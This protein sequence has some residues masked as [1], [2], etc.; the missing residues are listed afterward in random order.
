MAD[1]SLLQI[2]ADDIA[3]SLSS[4]KTALKKVA[5]A[6]EDKDRAKKISDAQKQIADC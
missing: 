5:K 1:S 2:Y 6:A 3:D 4:V